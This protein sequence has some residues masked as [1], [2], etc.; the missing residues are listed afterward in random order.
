MAEGPVM[1]RDLLVEAL[2]GF[3]RGGLC[4]LGSPNM[5][6]RDPWDSWDYDRNLGLSSLSVALELHES[7][8]VMTICHWSR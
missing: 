6:L 8:Y 4:S 2:K 7:K 3:H 5:T 1:L